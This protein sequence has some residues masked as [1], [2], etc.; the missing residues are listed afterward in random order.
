VWRAA[1]R[2]Y[3]LPLLIV[4]VAAVLGR[5]LGGDGGSV[6]GVVIGLAVGWLALRRGGRQQ[7]VPDIRLKTDFV[8]MR[9]EDQST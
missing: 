7:T 2:C 4:L 6:A 3:V 5:A 1:F 8:C 9:R